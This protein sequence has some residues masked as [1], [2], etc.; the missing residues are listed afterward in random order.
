MRTHRIAVLIHAVVHDRLPK[1]SPAAS[2]SCSL[3]ARHTPAETPDSHR[4]IEQGYMPQIAH[5][6][7]QFDTGSL[8]VGSFEVLSL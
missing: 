2:V 7:G 8:V 1:R 4:S 5:R 3:I 6:G